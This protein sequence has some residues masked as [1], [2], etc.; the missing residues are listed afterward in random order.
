MS[1]ISKKPLIIPESIKFKLLDRKISFIGK[2]GELSYIIDESIK[3]Q[4]N[5]NALSIS[6]NKKKNNAI[7]GMT[8][9]LLKN[10]VKGVD[11]GFEKKLKLVGVGYKAKIKENFLELSLGFSHIVQYAP[12]KG[13]EIK[14]SSNTELTIFGINKQLVGQTAAE[15]RLLRKPEPYKGKGI[16]YLGE[17][18]KIKDSKKK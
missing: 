17:K 1:R 5:K 14:C 12:K 15:I 7:L 16:R 2:H 3:I 6:T 8:S 9:I 11:T 18:I 10:M 4:V 13:I